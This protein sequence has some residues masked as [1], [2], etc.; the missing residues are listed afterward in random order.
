MV[1]HADR[2]R[3]GRGQDAVFTPGKLTWSRC[4]NWGVG[5]PG[6]WRSFETMF[7][8]QYRNL[9]TL[10]ATLPVWVCEVGSKEPTESDG[11]PVDTSHTKSAWYS[12][13]LASTVF[14]AVQAFVLFDVRKER[15]W[16]V[17]SSPSSLRVVSVAVRA[18]AGR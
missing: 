8:G 16:R 3:C 14:P 1:D 18:A 15:D 9:T 6:G 13:A 2:V 7:A 11:A 10:A 4:Y 12:A 17:A 5:G